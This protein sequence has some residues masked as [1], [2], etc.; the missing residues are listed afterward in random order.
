MKPFLSLPLAALALALGGCAF[1]A[2]QTAPSKTPSTVRSELAAQA[3]RVFWSTLHEGRYRDIGHALEIQT[4]AYLRDPADA[5]TAARAGWLHLWRLAESSRLP[6]RPATITN[7]AVL[8][9]RYFQEAVAL[10][11]A[12]PRFAGFLGATLLAEGSIHRDEKLT[13]QGYYTLLA[14]I[15]AWPEFNL[16]TAGY[17]MSMQPPGSERLRQAL[18]WQ[19]HTLDLCAGEPVDR[20]APDFGRHMARA[21]PEGPKRACWN[22]WIAP[23]NFEGFFLN[24]GDMLVRSGD[25]RTARLIYANARHSPD[26]AA[27]PHRAVLEARIRD[28]QDNVAAFASPEGGPSPSGASMLFG[29]ALACTACHQRAAP[30]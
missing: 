2:V 25:W 16:F 29:S 11:P 17:T 14:A 27:W 15:D 21:T 18:Q 6:D 1:V 22:S 7:D 23:H 20:Q 5:I 13:R 3:D 28:A 4:A 30:R 8:A 24:M 10:D 9:R 26:Y 12:E 19:W